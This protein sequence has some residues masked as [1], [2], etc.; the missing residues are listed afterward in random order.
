MTDLSFSLN[1]SD[2]WPR[3]VKQNKNTHKKK[4]TKKICALA[5]KQICDYHIIKSP[6]K[7]RFNG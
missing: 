5:L 2:N 6:S 7:E 3:D 4:K 1:P